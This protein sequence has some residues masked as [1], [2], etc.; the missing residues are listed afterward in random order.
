MAFT[1][2]HA[3]LVETHAFDE[4]QTLEFD[5]VSGGSVYVEGWDQPFAEIRIN[6]RGSNLE[7]W[8]ISIEPDGE[9][10]K[11]KAELDNRGSSNLRTHV[12]APRNLN[13]EFQSAGGELVLVGVDGRFSGRTMGGRLS[14]TGVTGQVDLRTMGGTIEILDSELDGRVKTG[15]GKVTLHNVVGDVEASSGGGNVQYKNVRASDGTLRGPRNL[16]LLTEASEDTVLIATQGGAIRIKEALD[17]A[18]VYTG[19]GRINISNASRFVSARTG[20]GDID[21]ELEQGWVSATTGAGDI[22][23]S[24]LQDSSGGGDV[25]LLSGNGDITLYLPADF[26]MDLDVD[27]AFTRNSKRGYRIESDFPVE[28]QTTDDWDYNGE[29]EQ[30]ESRRWDS[31]L[32]T[33]KRHILGT[34]VTGD[35]QHKVKIRTVNGNVFI[36]TR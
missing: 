20:G 23:V 9:S 13:V 26:S 14:F 28:Q 11:V 32:S 16:K 4:G 1:A 34:L 25:T 8:Q 19:G 21:I 3:E 29:K 30:Q 12:M 31:S 36:N 17:G 5:M 6:D 22:Q 15:G 24:I 7:D 2:A 18:N 27:L 35:G 33:P 10:L